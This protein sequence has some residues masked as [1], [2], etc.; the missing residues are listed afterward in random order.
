VDKT[1]TPKVVN[2]HMFGGV[3]KLPSNT[4]YIGRPGPYGNPYSSQSGRYTKEECVALHR[5]HLY[6]TLI[7]DPLR[8]SVLRE[9]LDGYDLACWCKQPKRVTGCHG[10][11]FLHIFSPDLANR[12]YDKTAL[13]YLMD[14]LRTIMTK[15]DKR[16]QFDIDNTD[17]LFSYI[18]FGDVRI[19]IQYVLLIVK[20]KY[21]V[22]E[23][24]L[25]F[26]AFL[27]VELELAYVDSDVT[28]V[29][30]R[31]N[32]LSWYIDS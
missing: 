22:L 15:F 30:Y 13:S 19:N 23:D 12:T 6:E 24:L 28:M 16:I 26:I 20:E 9:D 29:E 17:Y 3:D 8:L 27:V 21:V 7:K 18:H 10:D 14:D 4:K 5:V 31:F 11:N 2:T 25:F 1:S 32:H